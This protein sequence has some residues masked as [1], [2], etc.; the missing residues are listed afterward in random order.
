MTSKIDNLLK[1]TK[2]R[3]GKLT[4]VEKIFFCAVAEGKTADCAN[5]KQE[6]ETLQVEKIHWLCT[7]PEAQKFITHHGIK[8]SKAVLTGKL[9]LE[10]AT[11]NVPLSF[12]ECVFKEPITL[13]QAKTKN[14]TFDNTKIV[15]LDAAQIKIDGNLCLKN[16]FVAKGEV[17]FHNATISKNFNCA[18][19]KFDNPKGNA[20]L[21]RGINISGSFSGNCSQRKEGFEARGKVDLYGAKI[22]QVLDCRNS[23]FEN[24]ENIAL[25]VEN[26]NIGIRVFLDEIKANGTVCFNNSTI[27]DTLQ[28]FNGKFFNCQKDA[29]VADQIKTSGYL[30]LKNCEIEGLVRLIG[31]E[32]GK[33]LNCEN[34]KIINSKNYAFLAER[35]NIGGSVL[36]RGGFEARCEVKISNMNIGI[37]LDCGAGTFDNPQGN[38]IL[39]EGIKVK[40]YVTLNKPNRPPKGVNGVFEAKGIVNLRNAEIGKNLEC[41][42]GQF[43]NPGNNALLI[44]GIKV[45]GCLSLRDFNA[46][47]KVNLR[48]AK[49]GTLKDGKKDEEKNWSEGLLLDGLT[50]ESISEEAPQNSETRL[51]WLRRQDHQ[52]SFALQPYEQLAKVLTAKGDEKEAKKILIAQKDDLIQYQKEREEPKDLFQS[53][54]NYVYRH[55]VAYGYK[56]N[57]ALYYI[58][59]LIII[60]AFIFHLGSNYD[61]FLSTKEFTDSKISLCTAPH[62]SPIIYS[63][64]ASIPVIDFHQLKYCIPN[65]HK[66][67]WGWILQF[68]FSLHIILGWLFTSLWV[69][70]LTGLIRKPTK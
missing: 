8:I 34:S 64:D 60:G 14:I 23:K 10:L 6:K 1:I 55:T 50:Y 39:A 38:A 63:L 70:G 58:F 16:G 3:F 11:V 52:H 37:N 68:Y 57:Q 27:G 26:A 44:E 25:L 48:Y 36:L 22:E 40:G 46:E 51:K 18:G 69:A 62:F 5:S 17:N 15:S 4:K 43:I 41:D 45:S 28:C 47:G 31:A 2:E 67:N 33:D 59:G 13:R 20:L 42:G 65:V 19:G 21:A 24:G 9:N 56:P 30:L 53:I 32:I 29:F 49:V 7:V 66:S 61:V 12:S 54:W 35:S